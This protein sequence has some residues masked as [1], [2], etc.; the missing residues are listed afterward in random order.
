MSGVAEAARVIEALTGV[1][2]YYVSAGQGLASVLPITPNKMTRRE[3]QEQA[4]RIRR[5]LTLPPQL[6]EGILRYGENIR[7]AYK[8]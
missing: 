8:A 2:A 6:Q 1:P 7:K 5:F 4:A 3:R